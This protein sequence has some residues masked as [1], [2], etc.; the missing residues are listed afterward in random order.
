MSTASHRQQSAPWGVHRLCG[1]Q[2]M[3]DVCMACT[4]T[5]HALYPASCTELKALALLPRGVICLAAVVDGQLAKGER[6]C[7]ASSGQEYE[8]LECGLLTPEPHATGRLL[9]GQVGLELAALAV[10]A[11][12]HHHWAVSG[13]P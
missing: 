1:W 13:K 8:V 9:T 10:L 4:C 12:L 6:I 5:G 11:H 7:S 2:G 3:C